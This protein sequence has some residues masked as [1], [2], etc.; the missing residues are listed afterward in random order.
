MK[1]HLHQLFPSPMMIVDDILPNNENDKVLKHINELSKTVKS[2]GKEWLSEV[3]NTHLTH[4]C[5]KDNK[6][7]YIHE[8]VKKFAN[9]FA[10]LYGSKIDYRLTGTAQQMNFL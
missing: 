4:N 2:G 1:G 3:Y 10:E 6:F 7:S 8:R 5:C 9:I